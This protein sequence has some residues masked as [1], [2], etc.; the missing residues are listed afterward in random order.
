VEDPFGC[1]E[2]RKA[3]VA[4]YEASHPE[5][6]IQLLT[7]SSERHFTHPKG[8]IMAKRFDSAVR[9]NPEG[10]VTPHSMEHMT[11]IVSKMRPQLTYF[12]GKN[13]F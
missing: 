5:Y 9:S 13:D 4:M 2:K 7:S 1:E 8:D 6:R 10:T 12:T 11:R 3:F